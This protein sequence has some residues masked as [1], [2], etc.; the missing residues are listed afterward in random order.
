MLTVY[1]N[2]P[3]KNLVD[4][5]RTIKFDAVEEVKRPLRVYPHQRNRTQVKKTE[6]HRLKS[7]PMFSDA[8]QTGRC[9]TFDLQLEFPVFP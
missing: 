4:K 6:L 5:H 9:E 2:H 8:S 7:Q 1:T 3:D